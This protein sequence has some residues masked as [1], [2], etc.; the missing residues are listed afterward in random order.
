MSALFVLN[1]NCLCARCGTMILIILNSMAVRCE[2]HGLLIQGTMRREKRKILNYMTAK[3]MCLARQSRWYGHG[4]KNPYF[5]YAEIE[6]RHII[7][8]VADLRGRTRVGLIIARQHRK[9]FEDEE[10]QEQYANGHGDAKEQHCGTKEAPCGDEGTEQAIAEAM[11]EDIW[12]VIFADASDNPGGG[13]PGDGT[14]LLREML[15]RDLPGTI[16]GYMVDPVAV[17]QL[18]DKA[19]G[20]KVSFSLG[21][22]H[23]KIFTDAKKSGYVRVRVDGNMYELSEDIVLDKNKKICLTCENACSRM[24]SALL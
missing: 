6:L 5:E 15:R 18:W 1:T 10:K 4:G 13:C 21:G 3:I 8:A 17:E 20:E 23:E 9:W 14:H 2:T 11:Q 19:V 24:D 16:F 22:R 12:P 7:N